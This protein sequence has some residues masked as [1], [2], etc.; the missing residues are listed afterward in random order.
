MPSRFVEIATPIE[1]G[2]EWA[3]STGS[4]LVSFV[5][6]VAGSIHMPPN[7][8]DL[9][10]DQFSTACS[11]LGEYDTFAEIQGAISR[12]PKPCGISAYIFMA[13]IATALVRMVIV[14]AH[15]SRIIDRYGQ[16]R[17]ACKDL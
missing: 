16:S 7:I 3:G 17:V 9:M 2:V 12:V 11:S 15:T 5:K 1:D 10:Y 4:A 14:K 8:T 13:A 6:G